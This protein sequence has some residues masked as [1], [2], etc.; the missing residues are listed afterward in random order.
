[1]HST[2]VVSRRRRRQH[3]MLGEGRSSCL[4][5]PEVPRL[6]CWLWVLLKRSE[7][8][9][10]QGG[11]HSDLP[12]AHSSVQASS[13]QGQPWPTRLPAQGGQH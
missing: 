12:Q 9:V 5:I 4:E 11:T 2:E 10:R 1:M 6:G 7:E 8:P 13:T 3:N